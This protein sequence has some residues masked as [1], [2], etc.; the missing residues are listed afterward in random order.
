M[1]EIHDSV[2][3]DILQSKKLKQRFVGKILHFSYE[4]A[5]K[6]RALNELMGKNY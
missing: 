5:N 1:L 3:F 2:Y 6:V 4:N